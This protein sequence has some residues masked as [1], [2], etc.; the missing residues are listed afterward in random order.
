M[1]QASSIRARREELER[2][3]AFVASNLRAWQAADASGVGLRERARAALF[4]SVDK[5]WG[6]RVQSLVTVL[7]HEVSRLKR[8]EEALEEVG[9][10]RGFFS[11]LFR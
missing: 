9:P 5:R 3:H 7:D 10:K 8:E 11:K 6:E 1:T 2:I 4:A